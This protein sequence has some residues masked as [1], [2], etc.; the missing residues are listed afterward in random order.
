MR[1]FVTTIYCLWLLAAAALSLPPGIEL[2]HYLSSKGVSPF[3]PTVSSQDNKLV[4][5]RH[6]SASQH[7]PVDT[8]DIKDG[9]YT[10]QEGI[11]LRANAESCPGIPDL[12]HT[13]AMIRS[14]LDEAGIPWAISGGFALILYGEP[15]RCTSDIDVL[16]QTDIAHLRNRLAINKN[17]IVPGDD[18]WANSG[19]LRTYYNHNNRF[20]EVD[21]NIAGYANTPK[22]LEGVTQEIS[23][24]WN[25]DRELAFVNLLQIEKI[26]LSKVRA[27]AA[28]QR[29]KDEKDMK[30]IAWII[31]AHPEAVTR[32]QSE[33]TIEQRQLVVRHLVATN[34]P[35]VSKA[36]KLLG[37]N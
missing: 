7:S 25:S 36:K 32:A 17:F 11:W 8:R 9:I 31:E 2:R 24:K 35:L 10:K 18:W 27:L 6:L 16:I 4:D 21:F 20:F 12:M 29:K 13:T 22:N 26:L 15:N 1:P 5:K 19:H 30:D 34:S 14:T 3:Q 23:P 33:L 37:I 28:P